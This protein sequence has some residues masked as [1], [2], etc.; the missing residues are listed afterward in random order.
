MEFIS[1]HI[2]DIYVAV[3]LI[4]L[5]SSMGYELFATKTKAVEVQPLIDNV[6]YFN[7]QKRG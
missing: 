5:V 7:K 1:E 2:F 6:V 4:Y 3:G